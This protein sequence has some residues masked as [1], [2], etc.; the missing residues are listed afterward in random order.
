MVKESAFHRDEQL[1]ATTSA[2]VIVRRQ[3]V[4]A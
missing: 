1:V 2:T 3:P 4:P